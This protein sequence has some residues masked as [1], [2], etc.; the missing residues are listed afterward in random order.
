[1]IMLTFFQKVIQAKF[2]IPKGLP[3]PTLFSKFPKLFPTSPK[4]LPTSPKKIIATPQKVLTLKK[5]HLDAPLK[6]DLAPS[7]KKKI[8]EAKLFKAE[9]EAFIPEPTYV[10]PQRPS[11]RAR[12]K[13]FPGGIAIMSLVIIVIVGFLIL[14]LVKK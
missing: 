3:D 1:M 12:M 11:T 2:K 9:M 13:L 5:M 6:V 4:P 7:M 14:S 10:A 8:L